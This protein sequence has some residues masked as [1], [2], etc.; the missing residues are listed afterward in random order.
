M[1]TTKM[2]MKLKE[3]TTGTTIMKVEWRTLE[4]EKEM[5]MKRTRTA[6]RKISQKTTRT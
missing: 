5:R 1:T 3:M 4:E 2:R 6:A